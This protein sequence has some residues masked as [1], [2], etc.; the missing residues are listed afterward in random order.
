MDPQG[1]VLLEQAGLAL[2]DAGARL[3]EPVG[4]RT[5]VYVG[6]MHMEYIQL[7]TGAA[8]HCGST[9]CPT[10]FPLPSS[11]FTIEARRTNTEYTDSYMA[12][13]WPT[14]TPSPK[15][16]DPCLPRPILSLEA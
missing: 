12:L 11:L 7:L 6:V 5:G 14:S 1:R 3:G 8:S 4:A 9:P 2:A 15:A 13:A 10:I 16:C